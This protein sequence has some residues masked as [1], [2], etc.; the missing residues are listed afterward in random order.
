MTYSN[1]TAAIR[2]KVVGSWN[3]H[4]VLADT[5][6]DFFVMTS[7]T[8]GTLGTPGQGNYAAACS[9]L[10]SLARYRCSTGRPASSLVLPMVLGVGYVAEHAE[11]E[12]ALK[13]K[14]IYGIDEDEL[15]E[16]FEAAILTQS[17]ANPIDH[18]IAGMDAV[19]LN[20]TVKESETTDDFWL[21]DARFKS[22][23]HT[24]K[25]GSGEKDVAALNKQ[26]IFHTIKKASTP[27]EAVQIVSNSIIAKLARLLLLDMDTFEPDVKS[28]AAYGLDSMIGAELRNW[29][30]KD[31]GLDL[32][33]QQLLEPT[34]TITNLA[35]VVCKNHDVVFNEK[36]T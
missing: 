2:P 17:S 22:L 11:I 13:R 30:F 35:T 25:S 8:S 24:I 19:K 23:I 20:K 3:L 1:W 9:Y 18:I 26:S 14:G 15:V 32:P 16:A 5:P 34:L 29:I 33:F 31:L 27:A 4:T 21:D 6:L 7:S 10:D 36:S 12:E 28:I